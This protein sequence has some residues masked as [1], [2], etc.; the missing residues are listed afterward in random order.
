MNRRSASKAL[1]RKGRQG[2]NSLA[3]T[4]CS[5]D[6]YCATVESNGKTMATVGGLALLTAVT[7]YALTR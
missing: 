6:G 4:L 3:F 2:N 1:T 7:L 5:P